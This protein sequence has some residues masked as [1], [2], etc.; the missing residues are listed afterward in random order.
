[1][2]EVFVVPG[3]LLPPDVLSRVVDPSI[4]AVPRS[5]LASAQ[6]QAYFPALDSVGPLWHVL[7]HHLA[8]APDRISVPMAV[9]TSAQHGVAL[10]WASAVGGKP[11][12]G[13]G[14]PA[15]G[16]DT[17]WAALADPVHLAVTTDGVVLAPVDRHTVS[18][19]DAAALFDAATACL[20]DAQGALA[21][22]GRE[23]RLHQGGGQWLLSSPQDWNVECAGLDRL[24][25]A[26]LHAR[27]VSGPDASLLRALMND[28]QMCWHE[29]P[30][31][32]AR[33]EQG[34]PPINS[35]WV[36]AP[37]Q[38]PRH[39]AATERLTQLMVDGQC[40]DP[41]G[42]RV[43]WFPDLW[44]A[45]CRRDW[46]RWRKQLPSVLDA[47]DH[48][49][50]EAHAVELVLVGANGLRSLQITLPKR[51]AWLRWTRR[52]AP[53]ARPQLQAWLSDADPLP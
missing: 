6:A 12:T 14:Q 47:L 39:S 51:P 21:R 8:E 19:D 31:N 42:V 46:S 44:Q 2:A 3:A 22:A 52:L 50:H 7:D 27:H 5:A 37:A 35:L 20:F 36:H 4:C 53:L 41:D 40:S 13:V 16:A 25:G 15:P 48:A 33:L 43:R 29:H 24:L 9:W 11:G 1:M 32:R 17:R 28:I 10:P 18:A 45:F 34:L 49:V 38:W 26:R 23:V 30:V